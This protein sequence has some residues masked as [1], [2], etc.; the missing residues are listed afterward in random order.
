MP[1]RPSHLG[2]P[3]GTF[4]SKIV[5]AGAESYEALRDQEHDDLVLAVAMALWWGERSHSFRIQFLDC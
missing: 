5:R 1:K 4:T 2:N 3:G